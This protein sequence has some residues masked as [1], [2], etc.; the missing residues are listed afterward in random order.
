MPR[1]PAEQ[2][3]QDRIRV[4]HMLE[5]AERVARYCHGFTRESLQADE[6]RMLA[7]VKSIEVVGEASTKISEEAAAR[8]PAIDWQGI[9][10]MRN[11]LVHGYDSIDPARVWDAVEIDIPPLVVALTAALAAWPTQPPPRP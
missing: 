4:M 1:D 10:R 3:H 7:V 8:I 5:A 11:R 6:M 2:L 9:R